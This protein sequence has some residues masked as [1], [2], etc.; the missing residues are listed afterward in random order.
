[1]ATLPIVERTA[2]AIYEASVE[3]AHNP[4]PWVSLVDIA[5]DRYRNMACAALSVALAEPVEALP[6]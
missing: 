4:T 1:M 5:R 6:A 3:K 2:I